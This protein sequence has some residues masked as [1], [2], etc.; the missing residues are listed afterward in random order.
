MSLPLT[1]LE[2]TL[3]TRSTELYS[4]ESV[5]LATGPTLPLTLF[6]QVTA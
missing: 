2:L 1:V 6:T 5:T 4:S 3:L